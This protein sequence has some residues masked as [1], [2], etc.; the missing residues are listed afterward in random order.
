MLLFDASITLYSPLKNDET[1]EH[2]SQSSSFDMST[3]II[4]SQDETNKNKVP[5]TLTN[6]D[7]MSEEESEFSPVWNGETADVQPDDDAEVEENE[8]DAKLQERL[9]ELRKQYL[10]AVQKALD[11]FSVKGD[12]RKITAS[13]VDPPNYGD[14]TEGKLTEELAKYGFR[15]TTRAA[16]ISKLTR[17]W[18]ALKEKRISPETVPKK[19]SNVSNPVD[20]IRLKSKF[21][22]DILTYVPIPLVGLHREMSENGVKCSLTKLRQILSKEGVAFL[23]DSA[24]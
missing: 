9:R 12:V 5:Y 11:E 7:S 17:I 19:I 15:Y 6:N 23:E 20:F 4:P 18:F 22:E 16:A 24:V 8:A 13:S 3:F 21:Y 14:M 10:E 2:N 1:D